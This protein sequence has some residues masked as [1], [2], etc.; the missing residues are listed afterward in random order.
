MRILDELVALNDVRKE[1]NKMQTGCWSDKL[2]I[3]RMFEIISDSYKN[4]VITFDEM[5]RFTHDFILNP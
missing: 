4:N 1:S 3:L 5:Q 2:A